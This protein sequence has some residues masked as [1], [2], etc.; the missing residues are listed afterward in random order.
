MVENFIRNF[1]RLIIESLNY[2]L[3][4]KET[5]EEGLI[6]RDRNKRSYFNS[7][8]NELFIKGKL[9]LSLPLTEKQVGVLVWASFRDL[10]SPYKIRKFLHEDLSNE[11]DNLFV[12]LV[13]VGE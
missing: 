5:E 4:L 8:L 12:K 11:K 1:T 9:N 2:G 3:H 7:F 6:D 10:M 13:L